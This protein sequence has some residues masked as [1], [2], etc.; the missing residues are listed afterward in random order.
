MS[1]L[2][3]RILSIH[4]GNAPQRRNHRRYLERN[5]LPVPEW[6]MP[7]PPVINRPALA[8]AN[9]SVPVVVPIDLAEKTF[10]SK[11]P[12]NSNGVMT[13]LGMAATLAGPEKVLDLL[14]GK[15][16]FDNLS[17]KDEEDLVADPLPLDA[18]ETA[19]L[20]EEVCCGCADCTCKAEPDQR[21]PE[22]SGKYLM[23]QAAI[24]DGKLVPF[25]IQANPDRDAVEEFVLQDEQSKRPWYS[26]RPWRRK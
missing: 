2:E 8:S 11:R 17:L 7:H 14:D 10:A 4:G 6:L 12:K 9:E 15:D 24:A 23:Q 25:V 20:L 26:W 22:G 19:E 21:F 18:E 5:N 3:K 13:V 1:K 16:P